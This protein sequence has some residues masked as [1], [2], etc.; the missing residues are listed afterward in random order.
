MTTA[1]AHGS[2]VMLDGAIRRTEEFMGTM[3]KA[4]RK[5]Y[6]QFF[7][8]G[9]T[10]VFMASMFDEPRGRD[11]ITILDAGA[12]S[13]ILTVA[14]IERAQ[15]FK[16]LRGISIVC[17]ETDSKVLPLLGEN[18]QDAANRSSI[19]VS[20]EIRSDNYIVSQRE[21][22][23]ETLLSDKTACR[24]DWVIGNPPYRKVGKGAPEALAMPDVCH[25]AP[26]LYFLF[27]A[28]GMFNLR[29]GGELVYIMPRSWTSGAYFRRF[30]KKMLRGGALERM[31]LFIGRDG[32]FG[33][34]DVLQETVIAKF[35]KNPARRENVL[36]S[37]TPGNGNFAARTEFSAPY[38]DVVAGKDDYV[39]LA[40]NADELSVLRRLNHFEHTLPDIG[41]RMKTGLT[42]DFR[43]RDLIRDA[44]TP[45]SVPLFQSWHIKD[46]K[47]VFPAGRESEYIDPLRTGLVQRN[48]NYLFVKRF[49]SKEEKRRLQC[50]VYLSS[51]HAD[52]DWISTQNKVNFIA[53]DAALSDCTVFGLYVLFN[54]SAYD[55]FYRMLNGS[56]QV[57]ATEVNSMPVPSRTEIEEMGRSLISARNYEESTCDEI[58][59]RYL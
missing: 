13:G 4:T 58:L 9:E 24:Y 11:E 28:M 6:G 57:N 45:A 10:A 30:R 37:T 31:H 48:E 2:T 12:G 55:G 54:S 3:P 42:V 33:S 20:F 35:R 18:L 5:K 19:P 53:G 56:T 7:T 41:I 38:A 16:W 59:G 51:K 27:A 15:E 40:T 43:N 17:Y 1:M 22:Y 8:S 21:E 34:E 44:P 25:G 26:N 14:A 36:I 46:G 29:E 23:N 39:F 52:W 50:G 49:T 47:V 32:V